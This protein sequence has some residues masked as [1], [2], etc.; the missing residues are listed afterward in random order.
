MAV[1]VQHEGLRETS[2]ADIATVSALVTLVKAAYPTVD[3][4]VRACGRAVRGDLGSLCGASHAVDGEGRDD[5]MFGQA[6]QG[7]RVW[8][9]HM[10]Y[11]LCGGATAERS[12]GRPSQAA[13][14][15][16]W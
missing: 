4:E 1:K 12:T 3:Y 5:G 7:V 9:M 11:G 13:I 15:Q 10:R 6:K 2:A 8:C 14:L 16:L